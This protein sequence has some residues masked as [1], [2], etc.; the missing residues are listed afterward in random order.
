MNRPNDVSGHWSG[1]YTQ[2]DHRR[3]I[4][5]DLAQAGDRLTGTMNDDCTL[6]ERRVSELALEE[7]LAPGADEQIVKQLRALVPQAPAGPVL[8]EVQLPPLSLLDGEV[9]G[10]AVQFEKTYQG[11]T[12]A[13]YRIGDFRVGQL[14]EGHRV[15]YRGRLNE[16]GT[17]IEGRWQMESE[18][19]LTRR[20]EGHFWLRRQV[21]GGD[22]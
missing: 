4:S 1:F 22:G 14:G 8:A 7:G 2:H 6:I 15:H 11:Q 9:V 5:A 17:E 21:L 19:G 3:T 13:G 20:I 12:F 10:R 18:T 16:D